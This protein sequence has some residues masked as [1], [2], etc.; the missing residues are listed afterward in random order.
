MMRF[1]L[2]PEDHALIETALDFGDWLA[3]H[4]ATTDDQRAAI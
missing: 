1:D 4:P 3:A 2:R